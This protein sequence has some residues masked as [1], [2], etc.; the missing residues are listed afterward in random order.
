MQKTA[1]GTPIDWTIGAVVF[2]A[3][4][5]SIAT[6]AS[7]AAGAASHL[8]ASASTASHVLVA[9]GNHWGVL[10]LPAWLMTLL[11]LVGLAAALLACFIHVG[12][13]DRVYRRYVTF[14]SAFAPCLSK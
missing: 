6:A 12:Q 8:S 1:R 5:G 14:W 7:P 4:G 3:S 9:P 2:A 11:P 13:R 10:V